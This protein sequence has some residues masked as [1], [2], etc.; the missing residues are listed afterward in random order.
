VHPRQ[1]DCGFA[2][3]AIDTGWR[4]PWNG[5]F[6]ERQAFREVP[7]AASAVVILG[8]ALVAVSA[9]PGHWPSSSGPPGDPGTNTDLSQGDDPPGLDVVVQSVAGGTASGGHP[10]RRPAADQL[11]G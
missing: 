8:A 3:V 7:I 1:N 5:D 11:S 2:N 6:H 9:A 4:E 10:R